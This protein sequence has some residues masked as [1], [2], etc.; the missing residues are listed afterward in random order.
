M[1]VITLKKFRQLIRPFENNYFL[2]MVDMVNTSL[3]NRDL[4]SCRCS[5]VYLFF[6][7]SSNG[8]KSLGDSVN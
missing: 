3:R 4:W 8:M 5:K 7:L 2:V 1:K 6:L